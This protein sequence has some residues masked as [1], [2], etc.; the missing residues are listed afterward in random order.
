MPRRARQWSRAAWALALLFGTLPLASRLFLGS[1]QFQGA[2]ELSGICLLL[3]TY[4]YFIGRRSSSPVPDS[5]ALVNR[6]IGLAAEGRVKKAIALL[7]KAIRLSPRFWQAYQYRGELYLRQQKPA[8]ALR[9][10]E[11]AISLA[12]DEPHLS[13]L[14]ERAAALAR[15]PQNHAG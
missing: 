15:V 12:P 1:W 7:T 13:A 10:F 11:Q 3:G 14:R 9:D 4:L 5:A 6:A 2:A 8:P